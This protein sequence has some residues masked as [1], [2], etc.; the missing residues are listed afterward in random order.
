MFISIAEAAD[1][2]TTATTVSTNAPNSTFFFIAG[3][4]LA[5]AALLLIF[6]RFE[7]STGH[8]VLLGLAAALISLPFVAS[9]EWG[10]DGFK[11]VTKEVGE[12]LS[13]EIAKLREEQQK[14]LANIQSLTEAAAANTARITA[15]E[16]AAENP[17][18]DLRP[19]P[20][21]AFKKFDPTFFNDLLSKGNGAMQLNDAR[22]RDVE[23]LK[24]DFQAIQPN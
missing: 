15:L 19:L 12:K 13:D 11:L 6:F 2:V 3:A 21:P 24:Q 1:A 23:R 4:I 9:F 7:V 22:L 18:A 5:F 8:A 16:V 17:N 14:A 10:K 20:D